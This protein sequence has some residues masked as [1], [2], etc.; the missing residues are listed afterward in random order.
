MG[1][2]AQ[3]ASP[4]DRDWTTLEM[5]N[6]FLPNITSPITMPAPIQ[7]DSKVETF[8]LGDFQLQSGETIEGES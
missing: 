8:S 1:E 7:E 4:R 6:L 2:C 3:S 5:K